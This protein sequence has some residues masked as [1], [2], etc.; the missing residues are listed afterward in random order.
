LC[1]LFA[2][3]LLIL[4]PCRHRRMRAVQR[5]FAR[6]QGS[7]EALK[8]SHQAVQRLAHQVLLFDILL[9]ARL[10]AQVTLLKS[11]GL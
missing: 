8:R 3:S 1:P 5:E 10:C 6:L 7:G 4:R 11:Y 2:V 9:F